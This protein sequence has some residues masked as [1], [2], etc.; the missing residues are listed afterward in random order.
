[1]EIVMDSSKRVTRLVKSYAPIKNPL[2]E[3]L[4]LDKTQQA[5][6]KVMCQRTY[7][8]LPADEF[9]AKKY[10]QETDPRF[11]C[12]NDYRHVSKKLWD[13]MQ[14]NYRNGLG[15]KTNEELLNPPQTLES[16][17]NSEEDVS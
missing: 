11:L 2:T 10:K 9:Y 3:I 12:N 17:I 5:P 7:E 8:V 14:E 13:E 4:G 1:M 6:L 16:F 15:W